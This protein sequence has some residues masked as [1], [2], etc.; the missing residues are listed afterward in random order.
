MY[1]PQKKSPYTGLFGGATT[2]ATPQPQTGITAPAAN[3]TANPGALDKVMSILNTPAGAALISA[4][5]AGL[6]AYGANKSAEAGREQNARQF[7]AS[8]AQNQLDS[9]RSHQQN[10]A[11][12]SA[13]A[14]PL[15]AEQLFGQRNAVLGAILGNS[16]NFSAT[17]GDP[18]VAAAMGNIQGGM[19]LPEGGLDPAMLE[20]MFGDKSTM[21]SIANRQQA[22]G[23]INPRH[24]AMDL[25]SMYGEAGT[26]ASQGVASANGLELDRQL[27]ESS[28]QREIIQR[29]ID[30]DIRGELQPQKKEGGG[31][32]FGKILKG[33][34]MGASFIPGVGQIVA[35]IATGLGGLINGDGLKSSLINAGMSAIPGLGAAGKLGSSV[36]QF[37]KKPIG[38]AIMGGLK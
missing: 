9:D 12:A 11:I 6:S 25:S 23:Q 32:I 4:G 16:R 13:N 14:S 35:P 19:R 7:Q 27:E 34:G 5:G 26:A 10:A 24:Q 15:G 3:P 36:Q 29:A 21:D 28:R 30:E 2:S 8:M 22:V 18:A 31:N 20:R 17:P 33:V 37:A 38:Q 1:P